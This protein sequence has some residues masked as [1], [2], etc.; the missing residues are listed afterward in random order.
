[1]PFLSTRLLLLL[2]VG[3]RL[4]VLALYRPGG[5]LGVGEPYPTLPALP[6]TDPLLRQLAWGALLLP[7]EVGTLWLLLQLLRHGEGEEEAHHRATLW[8]LSPLPLWAWLT[9][10]T[11]LLTFLLLAAYWR[12][13]LGRRS[14][15]WAA[16]PLAFATL[17]EGPQAALTALLLPF[18]LLLV[19]QP[20]ATSALFTVGALLAGPVAERLGVQGVAAT[21]F[22]VGYILALAPALAEWLAMLQPVL[23]WARWRRR[24]LAALSA[25]SLGLFTLALFVLAPREIRPVRLAAS[26]LA[27][28]LR[29]VQAAPGGWLLTD[30]HDLWEQAVGLGVGPVTARVVSERNRDAL[31]A[32][33]QAA[34]ASL[35]LLQSSHERAAP[36]LEPLVAAF[37]PASEQT[38]ADGSRLRRFVSALDAPLTPVAEGTFQDGV[39]LAAIQLPPATQAG[40][41]LPLA[42]H[43]DGDPGSQT[44]FLH[45]VA[46]DGSLVSQRDVLPAPTPDRHALLLPATLVPGSYTLFVG[47]YDPATAQRLTL[48]QGG[49]TIGFSVIVNSQ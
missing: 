30:S 8:A 18:I 49:D 46:P 22:Q 20:A 19:P 47:R 31:L 36:L 17:V 26:P 5:L 35:W 1:M 7:F 33:L 28:A 29:E 34:P 38:L 3:F 37:Y 25:A 42:L 40:A 44:L 48:S 23:G 2:F 12:F 10:L 21:A 39:T 4:A 9:S 6:I 16:L 11:P 41:L 27:P 14:W 13:P 43:W 32:H 15:L 45:L 24:G